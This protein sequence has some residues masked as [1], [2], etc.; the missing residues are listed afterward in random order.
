MAEQI[1]IMDSFSYLG[2]GGPIQLRGAEEEFRVFEEYEEHGT[3]PKRIFFGRLIG[4]GGRDAVLAYS[5]KKRKY[6]STTSMDAELALLMA[7]LT[8]ATSGK[9]F[10]DPFVGTGSLTIACAHFGAYVWGSDIDGRTVRGKDGVNYKS[11]FGQYGLE[12]RHMGGFVS[13]L[14]HSPLR[15]SRGGLLDG[16]VCDPPYGVREG[17]RVL[18]RKDGGHKQ[19]YWVDGVQAHLSVSV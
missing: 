18:G 11:S 16:I 19:I 7:N 8:L 4:F 9:L 5:L 13:D 3:E 14:T 2:L 17:L 12:G 15:G 1:E 6:I 10:Y